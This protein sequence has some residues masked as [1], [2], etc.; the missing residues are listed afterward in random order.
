MILVPQDLLKPLPIAADIQDALDLAELNDEARGEVNRIYAR[1]HEAK[2]SPKPYLRSIAA[3][4]AAVTRGIVAGYKKAK[5]TPYD[6]DRDPNHVA[7]FAP[8]AREIAREPS[9]S[10]SGMSQMERVEACVGET[11]AHLQTS[12]EHYRL[13]D[14]LHDDSGKPRREIVSQRLIYA[15]AEIF[16]RRYDVDMSRE[17]NAGPGAVDF[18]FTVGHDARLLVEVK[19]STHERLRDG[20]YEQLPAYANAE[21]VKLL[22]IRV[23]AIRTL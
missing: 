5:P 2:V 6:Y 14:V 11:I 18:R 12:M 3:S 22:V 8:I 1:A 20:Y 13:S 7:D 4:N 16:A 9:V 23:S 21:R 15:I 19:L 10:P 17:G